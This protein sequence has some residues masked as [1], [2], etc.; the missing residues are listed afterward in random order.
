MTPNELR[1][2]REKAENCQRVTC[3]DW[4]AKQVLALLDRLAVVSMERDRMRAAIERYLRLSP[5]CEYVDGEPD[6]CPGDEGPCHWC[7]LW[8]AIDEKSTGG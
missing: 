3:G 7:E 1:A 5:D 4:M 2:I 6:V 8:E